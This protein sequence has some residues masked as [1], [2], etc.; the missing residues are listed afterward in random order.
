MSKSKQSI[1]CLVILLAMPLMALAQRGG[2]GADPTVSSIAPAT[3]TAGGAGFALTVAG[4][5]FTL[6]SVVRW[7]GANLTTT[8]VSASQLQASI[9][10]ALVSVAGTAQ[11][12]V[13]TSGRGGGTSNAVAFTIN[14]AATTTTTTTGTSLAITTTSLPAGAAGTAYSQ[15][16]AASG[17]TAPYTWSTTSGTVPPGLSLSSAGAISGTPTTNGSYSFTARVADSA[18]NTATQGYSMVISTAPLAIATTSV[19]AGTAG[20]AYSTALAASGGTPPHNWS[21][22]SGALPPGLALS[23]AGAIS[24]NPATAGSYAFTAQVAD[25]ASHTASYTYTLSVAS[26]TTTSSTA[27][28]YFTNGFELGSFSGWSNVQLYGCSPNGAYAINSNRAYVHSGAYSAQFHYYMPSNQCAF[29]Q[30]NNIFSEI[31]VPGGLTHFFLRGYVYLKHPE[32]G[33][34][35]DGIQRKL[36]Y[37]LDQPSPSNYSVFLVVDGTQ[38]SNWMRFSIQNYPIGGATASYYPEAALD[39]DTWYCVELEI[40]NNTA[41]SP[42]WNGI[43]RVWI[44]GTRITIWGGSSNPGA[45]ETDFDL[46]RNT[47]YALATFWVGQQADRDSSMPVDEYRYWDDVVLSTTGPV[48]P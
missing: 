30:D 27:G 15:A 24:G 25:S 21:T 42:P 29:H 2:K 35:T 16:L 18:S 48:G 9:S 34:T 41:P 13:F 7:N 5:S 47:S 31:D 38:G 39:Y 46:N 28:V 12:T 36:F 6:G 43:V 32:A 10:S 23:A 14:P 17:G 3:A 11:I 45:H 19:P 1:V 22:T 8:F 40:K 20:T 44:N 26:A 37:I 33:G 4:S